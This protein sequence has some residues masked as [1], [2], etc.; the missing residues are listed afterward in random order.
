[1]PKYD[2]AKVTE[3][4]RLV[5]EG[6]LSQQDISS[7]TGIGL[8]TLSRHITEYRAGNRPDVDVGDLPEPRSAPPANRPRAPKASLDRVARGFQDYG[9]QLEQDAETMESLAEKTQQEADHL[10]AQAEKLREA[11]KVFSNG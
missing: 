2:V 3:A 10:K 6:Q 11:A 9:K 4:L 5:K 1:M 7:R 8:S